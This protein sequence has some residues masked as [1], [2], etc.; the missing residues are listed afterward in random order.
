MNNIENKPCHVALA[1]A[2]SLE[3]I[4][5]QAKESSS[6]DECLNVTLNGIINLICALRE[7]AEH[8]EAHEREK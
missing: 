8:S 2:V 6:S 3:H 4:L 1:A 7:Y 5:D